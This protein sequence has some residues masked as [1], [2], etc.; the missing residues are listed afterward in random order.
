MG[1]TR[2]LN[3]ASYR[4]PQRL[5]FIFRAKDARSIPRFSKSHPS[6]VTPRVKSKGSLESPDKLDQELLLQI[7]NTQIHALRMR[8]SRK[9][10]GGTKDWN[11][12]GKT[13]LEVTISMATFKNHDHGPWTLRNST[14]ITWLVATHMIALPGRLPTISIICKHMLHIAGSPLSY[15]WLHAASL[16]L[17]HTA[18]ASRAFPWNPTG[19]L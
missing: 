17:P 12:A 5:M 15:W 16:T 4:C 7:F 2:N 3:T 19:S 9:Q 18:L 1:D 6:S 13:W 10:K 8:N 14:L 11:S